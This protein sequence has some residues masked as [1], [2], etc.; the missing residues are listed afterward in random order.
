MAQLDN[1][2]QFI[3]LVIVG[4]LAVGVIQLV[5]GG[6]GPNVVTVLVGNS[7]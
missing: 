7:N 6:Y 5:A 2:F 4:G 3:G 1:Y